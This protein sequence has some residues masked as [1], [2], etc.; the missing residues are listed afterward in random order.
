MSDTPEAEV[1]S[2]ST[3]SGSSLRASTIGL[4]IRAST[5]AGLAPGK[6]ICILANQGVMAG[7]SFRAMPFKLV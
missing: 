1:P 7:S 6:K 3:T 2:T 5:R 4:V